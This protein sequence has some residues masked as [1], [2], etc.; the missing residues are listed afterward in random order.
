[1]KYK[2]ILVAGPSSSGKSTLARALCQEIGA[3]R[4]C[5]LSLDHYYRDLRHLSARERALIDF[6]HPDAW[7]SEKLI[8]DMGQLLEGNPVEMPE[9]DF[10]THLRMEEKQPISPCPFIIAEGLFALCYAKLNALA[11]LKIFVDIDDAVALQRRLERDTRERGRS[12]ESIARQFNKT[13]RAANRIHIRPSA[14]V[15]DIK[16]DGPS[17]VAANLNSI[18]AATNH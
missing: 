1:M 2:L 11:S 4:A 15:A 17:P 5:L 14:E 6:D 9:Y 12:P 7:E 10:T 16:L 13:V 3:D 8:K 18:L